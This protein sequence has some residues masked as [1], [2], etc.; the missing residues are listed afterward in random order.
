MGKRGNLTL[1]KLPHREDLLQ[2]TR[3]LV[4]DKWIIVHTHP[5]EFELSQHAD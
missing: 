4:G 5:G 1:G 2:P 3:I